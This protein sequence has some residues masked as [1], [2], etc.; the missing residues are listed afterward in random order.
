MTSTISK[1]TA[2]GRLGHKWEARCTAEQARV[3][4]AAAAGHGLSVDDL[5]GYVATGDRGYCTEETTAK[6][7]AIVKAAKASTE[8][9]VGKRIWTRKVAAVLLDDLA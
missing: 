4:K 7:Q 8:E 6:L 5:F 9:R 2:Q 3:I 1:L